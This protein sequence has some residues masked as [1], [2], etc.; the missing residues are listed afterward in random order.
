MVATSNQTGVRQG[1]AR[2]KDVM[3]FDQVPAWSVGAQLVMA[4]AAT[5]VAVDR[6]PRA[7]RLGR[8]RTAPWLAGWSLVLAAGLVTN[9]WVLSAPAHRVDQVAFV[10][11]VL[12]I[13][14]TVALVPVAARLA[15]VRSPRR[16]AVLLGI[17]G[18][19]RLLLW[20]MSDLVST[21][22]VTGSGALAYGSLVTATAVPAAVLLVAG[23]AAIWSQWTDRVE[24]TTF[25]S[26]VGAA[27]GVFG[28]S[29][30]SEPALA[31]VLTGWMFVP[32]VVAVLAIVVRR[33]RRRDDRVAVLERDTV[34]QHETIDRLATRT[35]VACDA[36]AAA[37][38]EFQPAS[39]R[40]VAS[41]AAWQLLEGAGSS[42][43]EGDVAS[44]DLVLQHLRDDARLDSRN[45]LHDL[46]HD[47][48]DDQ[49]AAQVPLRD[50]ERWLDVLAARSAN[51]P[52]WIVGIARDVTDERRAESTSRARLAKGVHADRDGAA[53]V[54]ARC[55][56]WLAAGEVV[57]LVVIEVRR[58]DEVGLVHGNAVASAAL[59]QMLHRVGW[60]QPARAQVAMLSDRHLVLVVPDGS[61]AAL[62]DLAARVH[63]LFDRPVVAADHEVRLSGSI[64]IVG[65]P[66]DGADFE[67]LSAR[68]R[69]V[70]GRPGVAPSTVWFT[71]A[72][73]DGVGHGLD[74]ATHVGWAIEHDAIQVAFQPVFDA[75]DGRV[76]SVEALV[77]CWHPEL[78]D[79]ATDQIVAAAEAHGRSATLF[80]AVLRASLSALRGWRSVG[81]VES[82]AVNVSPHLLADEHTLDMIDDE[83]AFAGLPPSALVLEVTEHLAVDDL[84][85][86]GAG[87]RAR[88]IRLAIDDFGAGQST[89]GRL[90]GLPVDVV[91]LDRSLVTGLDVDARRERVVALA[92]DV[93]HVLGAIV[94][95][96]G[97]ETAAEAAALRDAGIDALQGFGLCRPLGPDAMTE[98]LLDRAADVA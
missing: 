44:L 10:R 35:D 15:G 82:V 11:S 14:A 51:D 12:L 87:Y 94:V 48:A 74:V 90:A 63:A 9:V 17:V 13:T 49:L 41:D 71:A 7:L 96:E 64:G 73:L 1:A 57:H 97:V 69:A 16:V 43:G 91:K 21:H 81:L 55:N 62:D 88:G 38:W 36:A 3:V 52:A 66:D 79:I 45:R 8:D 65:G 84:A 5:S 2:G 4:G 28:A 77:R 60:A 25:M 22:T 27:I 53:R 98:F 42:R 20:P 68:A 24:R 34:A 54:A 76:R 6:L 39:G 58:L 30:W 32:L 23:L 19:A 26:G 56:A 18:A 83:L 92:N 95:A 89:V 40:F 67:V 29:S 70:A 85:S 37:W 47:D 93:A 33:H 72:D 50:D 78:G 80:H 75:V 59:E 46:L 31:E 61:R 86:S